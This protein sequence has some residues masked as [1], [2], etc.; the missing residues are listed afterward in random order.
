MIDDWTS[1][2]GA[3]IELAGRATQSSITNHQSPIP[4]PNYPT[5]Q[6]PDSRAPSSVGRRA[7]L[8]LAF[9]QRAGR[10]I[11]ARA[12]A[13]PPFRI[14]HAFDVDG[15]AYVILVCASP[16]IFAGD[17]FDTRVTVGPGA[18]VLLASQSSLQVHPGHD[19]EPA[20]VSSE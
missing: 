18:R 3:E 8:E 12:Y 11:L 15:A 19:C 5:T 9:E 17:R 14:G 6:L 7:R 16:G 2:T 10:T 13:E 1:S 4:L 20:I